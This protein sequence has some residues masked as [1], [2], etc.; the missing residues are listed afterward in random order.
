VTPAG[1]L[2][3]YITTIMNDSKFDD[4]L[5]TAKGH[6]PLPGSFRQ[7]VWHRIESTAADVSPVHLWLRSLVAAFI[8]P[9]GAAAGVFATVA[10]GIWLGSVSIPEAKDAK[11]A[12][13]ESISP[14]AHAY[15]K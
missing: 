3:I 14:F 4:L 9:W 15:R 10:A 7:G 6:V 13:A 2:V 12:Y 1:R 8:R 5:R 11:V